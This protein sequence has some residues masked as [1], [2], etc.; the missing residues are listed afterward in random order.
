[1]EYAKLRVYQVERGG[2]FAQ[3]VALGG[4]GVLTCTVQR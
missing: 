1:M 4:H 3:I 2:E